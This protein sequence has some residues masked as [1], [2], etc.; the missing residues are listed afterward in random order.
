MTRLHLFKAW[1]LVFQFRLRWLKKNVN[2][3]LFELFEIRNFGFFK[4]QVYGSL[5]LPVSI[6]NRYQS[7]IFIFFCRSYIFTRWTEIHILDPYFLIWKKSAVF[8]IFR[9]KIRRKVRENMWATSPNYNK[10]PCRILCA[11]ACFECKISWIITGFVKQW[12]TEALV[13]AFKL[14]SG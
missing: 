1:L 8:Q 14:V 4:K 2:W 5:F 12:R 7:L 3:S 9:W 11:A 10:P 13:P 6:L